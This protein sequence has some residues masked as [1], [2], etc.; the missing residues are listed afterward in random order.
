M[1]A[2]EDV[3]DEWTLKVFARIVNHPAVG[4]AVD[5]DASGFVSLHEVNHFVSRKPENLSTPVWFA[6]YV[7]KLSLKYH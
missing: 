5:E 1:L 7:L 4:E 2:G 6:L 3:T